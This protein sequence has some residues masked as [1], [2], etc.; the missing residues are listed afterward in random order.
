MEYSNILN[1]DDFLFANHLLPNSSDFVDLIENLI[2]DREDWIGHYCY[3][4]YCDYSKM[5]IFS[6]DQ[7]T[8]DNPEGEWTIDNDVDFYN[9][10]LSCGY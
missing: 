9:F 2:E 4:C 3:E 5:K 7:I 6:D 1:L 8:E 10:L